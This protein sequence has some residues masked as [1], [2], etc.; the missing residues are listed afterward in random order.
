MRS[1]YVPTRSKSEHKSER[2][3]NRSFIERNVPFMILQA[4]GIGFSGARWPS[5]LLGDPARVPALLEVSMS[6]VRRF[7]PGGALA[8]LVTR[9]HVTASTKEIKTVFVIAMENHNWA[10]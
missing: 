5:G 9:S 8:L 4:A 6:H 1:V 2:P 3:A 7:L 10:G